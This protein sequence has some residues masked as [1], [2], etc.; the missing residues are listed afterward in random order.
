MSFSFSKAAKGLVAGG[1]AVMIAANSFAANDG[2][3]GPTSEGDLNI[4]LTILDEVRISNL[5]D[6]DLGIFAGADLSGTSPACVFRSGTGNYEITAEGDGNGGAFELSDGTND[7]V[8]TVTYDDGAGAENMTSGTV[9]PGQTGGDPGSDICDN[10]GNNG[11][12][13][14]TVEADAMAA[15]P[16]GAYAGVLTLTVAPE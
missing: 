3:V 6:I 2:I 4:N 13:E 5:E 10:T 12:I 15:L 7:V 9:L 1:V 8:Y 14:V 11:T 16:A